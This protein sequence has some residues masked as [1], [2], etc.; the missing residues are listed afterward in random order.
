MALLRAAL[1]A[2]PVAA[3]GP[4]VVAATPERTA[5]ESQATLEALNGRLL[6]ARSATA[7][8]ESWCASRGL[9]DPARVTAEKI[10][11]PAPPD[12][13]KARALLAADPG[14]PLGYRHVRLTCGG[15]VLS[16]ARLWYRR[17]S[18]TPEMLETLARTDAPFGRVVASLRP[19]R[20]TLAVT[21]LWRPLAADFWRQSGLL[22]P[23]PPPPPALF[24]HEAALYDGNRVPFAYVEE[25][26]LKGVLERGRPLSRP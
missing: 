13:A 24:R 25:T 10:A 8:L 14:E 5:L 23:A 16:E 17:K 21:W 2:I 11:D 4:G 6:E 20:Q 1:L 19:S 3:A 26:Y 7:V 9:A 22:R 12:D 15:K 18:L